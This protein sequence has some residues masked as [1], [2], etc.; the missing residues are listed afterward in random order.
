VQGRIV[1]AQGVDDRNREAA[2]LGGLQ[3]HR[4]VLVWLAEHRLEARDVGGADQANDA[5]AAVGQVLDQLQDARPDR[6][7]ALALVAGAVEHGAGREQVL[8]DGLVDVLEIRFLQAGEEHGGAQRAV[9]AVRLAGPGV[10]EANGLSHRISDCRCRHR[11]H[12]AC[13]NARMASITRPLPR[14][15]TK[16]APAVRRGGLGAGSTQAAATFGRCASDSLIA[17]SGYA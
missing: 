17:S 10:L 14:K 15:K 16:P 9:D 1:P 3:H 13:R 8:V 5:L 12:P 2:D 7:H 4:V 6:E 11:L